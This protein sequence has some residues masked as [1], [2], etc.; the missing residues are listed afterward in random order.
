M[1]TLPSSARLPAGNGPKWPT[2]DEVSDGLL[3][4]FDT[5]DDGSIAVAE[6]SAVLDPSGTHA[7]ALNAVI[8]RFVGWIDTD[9]NAVISPAELA[10]GLD[11]LDRN[12][13]G[14]LSPADLRLGAAA[15]SGQAALL[16]TLLNDG[17]PGS[18]P[19]GPPAPPTVEQVVDA[20]MTRF[21][22]DDS[23]GITL[24]ELQAVLMPRG[25]RPKLTEA[26]QALVAA[27]DSN[28]DGVMVEA[29][30]TVVVSLLDADGDG[31]IGRE[32]KIPGPP[33]RD[34][35]V[36]LIGLLLPKLREF[37]AAVLDQFG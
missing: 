12:D 26:L 34:A 16:A 3:T 20:L 22:G 24:A 29:E 6:I 33:V 13:D 30:L 25:E 35:E 36:D 32:D 4:A 9:D 2:L 31:V 1:A 15:Q 8:E 14:L 37:D 18:R 23:G 21:D 17:L 28:A 27:V 7:D 10:A 19:P 5:N 11:T